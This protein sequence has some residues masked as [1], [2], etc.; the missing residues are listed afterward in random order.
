M[1]RPVCFDGRIEYGRTDSTAAA[2]PI[3]AILVI[4]LCI[5]LLQV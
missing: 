5:F 1:V 3:I 4:I 2:A